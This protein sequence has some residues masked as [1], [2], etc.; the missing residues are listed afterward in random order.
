MLSS[1]FDLKC[2]SY[3]TIGNVIHM[4][5]PRFLLR[6]LQCDKRTIGENYKESGYIAA[7]LKFAIDKLFSSFPNTSRNQ[8]KE[9]SEETCY[10]LS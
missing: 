4:P 1:K 9:L 2:A 3:L 6:G 10:K 7:K 8:V 5:S